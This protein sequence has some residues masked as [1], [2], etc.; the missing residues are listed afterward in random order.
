[1][2]SS[3]QP[4]IIEEHEGNLATGVEAEEESP[5]ETFHDIDRPWDPE[6]IRVATKNFSLRNV[7]DLIEENGLDLAP[8]FQRLR[9]WKPIQKSQLIESILLQIPL[10]AF[11]FAE[12]SDGTLS[13]VDGVQRLSTVNDFVKGGSGGFKLKG[14]EYIADVAGAS[15]SDLPPLWKRRIYNTQIVVHVIAPS[16][17]SAVMYDIFRRIN[18]GGTPLN[19]Q[20]IRHCI[21]K[22][23]GREF[24][25]TLVNLPEF[26]GATA[27]RLRDHRR[28]VD[29]ELALRFAAF[30]L[31]SDNYGK[32]ESTLDG[33]LLSALRGIDDPATLQDWQLENVTEAFASGLELAYELFGEFAFRKWP[34]YSSQKNPLN[35]ALFETWT[36]ELA[37]SKRED[38]LG[39]AEQIITTAREAMATDFDYISAIT[40]ST[41]DPRNVRVRFTRTRSFI[42]ATV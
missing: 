2:Q 14:L 38:V 18:T 7:L 6:S 21:S 16:T 37:K 28:M 35:R 1:M 33:F 20:E 41:G 22:P 8:D 5:D 31:G 26:D 32:E 11:Y 29:R 13:V 34:T 17:P 19:S 42:D 27:G 24:L 36:V 3:D 23:R 9:V 15:F 40:S 10:P 30:F 4:D 25:K 39:R 12:D